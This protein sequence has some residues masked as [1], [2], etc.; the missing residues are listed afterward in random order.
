VLSP[1]P[2]EEESMRNRVALV[3]FAASLA[4][5]A[6]PS[7]ATAGEVIDGGVDLVANGKVVKKSSDSLVVRTD[8]HGHKITFVV[9]SNTV[10]PDDL[11]K[12]SHVR[13]VY[14]ANGSKGQTA[15]KVTV[16][17]AKRA[18]R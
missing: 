11:A 1:G 5:L 2:R 12:G 10:L 13:V 8:D 4:L 7:A 16:T 14:R 15:E 6:G 3:V 17:A 9:D 18:S